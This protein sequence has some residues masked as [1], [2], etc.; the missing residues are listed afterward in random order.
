MTGWKGWKKKRQGSWNSKANQFFMDG[1]LVKHPLT[2]GVLKRRPLI[3]NGFKTK[4]PHY[5][6]VKIDGADTKR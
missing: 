3:F 4:R 2:L 5:L 1:F 6:K